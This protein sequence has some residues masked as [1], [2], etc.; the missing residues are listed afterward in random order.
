MDRGRRDH[1]E[2]C[3]V[4]VVAVRPHPGLRV[5]A[6]VTFAFFLVLTFAV[7]VSGFLLFGGGIV[8]FAMGA[9]VIGPLVR[10][11]F[12]DPR[13]PRCG[14]VTAAARQPARATSG[15]S[16]LARAPARRPS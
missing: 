8:V 12:A 13:C 16:G 4:D 6:V 2:R 3:A 9:L 15:E 11:A 1:C 14:C 10:T 7:G 5:L